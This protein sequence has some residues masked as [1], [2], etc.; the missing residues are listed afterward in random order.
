MDCF[1]SAQC[2]DPQHANMSVSD[3]FQE[4]DILPLFSRTVSFTFSGNY[5]IVLG[6]FLLFDSKKTLNILFYI[7]APHQLWQWDSDTCG[8]MFKLPRGAFMSAKLRKQLHRNTI[9]QKEVAGVHRPSQT[10]SDSE[11]IHSLNQPLE[12]Q[13]MFIDCL[14]LNNKSWCQLS[15]HRFQES[16]LRSKAKSHSSTYTYY[17]LQAISNVTPIL[18]K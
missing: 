7:L 5:V 4:G 6:I 16:W 11:V 18:T 10:G 9:F 2:A 3:L 15:Q 13:R 8:K 17:F 12:S 1:L 14:V